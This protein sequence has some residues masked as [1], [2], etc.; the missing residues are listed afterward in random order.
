MR[1]KTVPRECPLNGNERIPH[2]ANTI[3]QDYMPNVNDLDVD[4]YV[5]RAAGKYAPGPGTSLNDLDEPLSIGIV[6]LAGRSADARVEL[7][8][9]GCWKGQEVWTLHATRVV[10]S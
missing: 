4:L 2:P 5:F 9:R 3:I 10:I 6:V 8:G 1:I 7:S